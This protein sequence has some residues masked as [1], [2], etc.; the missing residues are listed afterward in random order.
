MK[1]THEAIDAANETVEEHG[2]HESDDE[3]EAVEAV[4]LYIWK[5]PIQLISF[6]VYQLV[7]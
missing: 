6:N 4:D 1:C 3:D 5:H 7:N 2:E